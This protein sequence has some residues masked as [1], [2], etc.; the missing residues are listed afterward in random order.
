MTQEIVVKHLKGE[1]FV[2][3]SNF[4]IEGVEYKGAIFTIKLPINLPISL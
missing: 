1:V 3:N 4:M 2:E